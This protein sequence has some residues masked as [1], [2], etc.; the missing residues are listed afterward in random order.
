M[1][2]LLW[3]FSKPVLYAS[4]I[5]WPVAAYI[6]NRWLNE[7]A[8]HVPLG[9]WPFVATTALTLVIALLTVSAQCWPVARAKPAAALRYE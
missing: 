7:F 5:A 6:M 9:T 8:Y 4:V 3:Q 2:M 1:R